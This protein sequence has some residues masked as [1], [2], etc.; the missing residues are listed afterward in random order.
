M[1]PFR[2][3]LW[4]MT[5]K[6]QTEMHIHGGVKISGV[7]GLMKRDQKF[8]IPGSTLKGK[9]RDALRSI[10]GTACIQGYG[11]RKCG[12]LSCRVF[13]EGGFS[14]SIIRISDCIEK[15]GEET[16]AARIRTQIAIDR[17]RKTAREG[18]L[19]FVETVPE[20]TIFEGS[21][22]LTVRDLTEKEIAMLKA[23]AECLLVSIGSGVSRGLGNV[24]IALEVME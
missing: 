12:C 23:A 24:K 14:P 2:D 20:G 8:I 21:V 17:F 7:Q 3:T 1:K 11:D 16:K 22:R 18:A 9:W 15:K 10:Q 19:A 5:I 6:T 13:G 4:K